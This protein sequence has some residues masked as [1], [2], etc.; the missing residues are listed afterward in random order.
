MTRIFASERQ[1]SIGQ[2]VTHKHFREATVENSRLMTEFAI[3]VVRV[4][5]R[6]EWLA[7]GGHS[8]IPRYFF[9]EMEMLD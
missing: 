3:K 5:T 6:E 2:I 9:Y 1:L 8:D 7:G 4:A